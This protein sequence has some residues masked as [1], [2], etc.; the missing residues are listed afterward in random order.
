MHIKD[1]Q[2]LL[3]YFL[4]VGEILTYF[5]WGSSRNHPKIHSAL[6]VTALKFAS[7]HCDRAKHGL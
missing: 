5:G 3:Y 2:R 7:K 6:W 4:I 1:K